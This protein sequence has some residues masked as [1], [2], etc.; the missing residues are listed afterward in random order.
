[1]DAAYCDLAQVRLVCLVEASLCGVLKGSILTSQVA[2]R[3]SINSFYLWA[4]YRVGNPA[5]YI[6]CIRTSRYQRVRT[7]LVLLA[8]IC[9]ARQADSPFVA[10]PRTGGKEMKHVKVTG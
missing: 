10:I 4:H 6:L 8:G 1:M 7:A 5:V 9:L 2:L 3:G